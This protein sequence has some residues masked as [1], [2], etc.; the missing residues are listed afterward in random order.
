MTEWP[1]VLVL[2]TRVG[3]SS[4]RVR[5]PPLPQTKKT[6]QEA[7]FFSLCKVERGLGPDERLRSREANRFVKMPGGEWRGHKQPGFLQISLPFRILKNQPM[8]GFLICRGEWKR[9]PYER[10]ESVRDGVEHT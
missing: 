3:A 2:K 5:I 9:E 1:I 10:S 8:A 4:P 7:C 6:G